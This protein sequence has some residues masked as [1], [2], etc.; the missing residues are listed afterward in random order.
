MDGSTKMAQAVPG[1]PAPD[2]FDPKAEAKAEVN[3]IKERRIERYAELR[4]KLRIRTIRDAKTAPVQLD[5]VRGL[6]PAGPSVVLVYGE[7][8]VGKSFWTSAVALA[9]ARGERWNGRRT[10]KTGVLYLS[11][12]G[13]M[14]LRI[15]AYEQ[16]HGVNL[17]AVHFLLMETGLDLSS[18]SHDDI[19]AV[20]E[21]AH[22]AQMQD[23]MQIGMLVIDTLARNFG[24]GDPDKSG[25]MSVF[26]EACGRFARAFDAV[27]VA[28]HHPGKDEARG[29]RN[30]YALTAGVDAQIIIKADKADGDMRLVEVEKQRDGKVEIAESFRLDVIDLGPHPSPDADADERLTSCAAIPGPAAEGS[31]RAGPKG[32]GLTGMP[33]MA[34]DILSQAIGEVGETIPQTSTIPGGVSG[35]RLDYWRRMFTVRYGTDRDEAKVAEGARKAFN[36]AKDKLLETGDIQISDPWVWLCR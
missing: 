16:A 18:P 21:A 35:V 19:D 27:V 17:E 33:K 9:V 36:R 8:S 5:L 11:S 6:F 4:R 26:V 25:D 20:I 28:V 15:R 22:E 2:E 32:A 3:R 31:G 12:E 34:R 10:R 7:S 29:P 13:R 14:G 24:G 23:G 30:S 1:D